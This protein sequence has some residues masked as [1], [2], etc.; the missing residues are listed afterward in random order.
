MPRRDM[1]SHRQARGQQRIESLLAAAEQLF[2]E[3]GYEQATTNLIAAKASVSPGTLYQFFPNKEAMAEVLAD[4]YAKRLHSLH[5]RVFSRPPTPAPPHK[6]IDALVDPFLDFHRRAPAFEALFVGA[7]VSRELAQRVQSLKASVAARLARLLQAHAPGTSAHDLF[8]AAEI[9]VGVFQG[10]LP[11]I[12]GLKG[13]RRTRAIRE[14][15][16]L[17]LR[18]LNP[19]LG[20]GEGEN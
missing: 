1:P 6:L 17:F 4:R 2:A 15:K 19:L 5:E 11:T 3:V 7:T 10:M 13:V 12:T 14:L 8:W 9:L 16:V 20:G 18:Y